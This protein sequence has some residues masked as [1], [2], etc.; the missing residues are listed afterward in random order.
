VAVYVWFG[1]PRW[2]DPAP[3]A[4]PSIAEEG[5]AVRVAVWL[6]VQ[7]VEAF[8]LRSG[9]IPGAQELGP[10]PPSVEYQRLDAQSY[11]LAGMGDRVG[12]TY[13]S[14]EPL[15]NLQDAVRQL[16]PGTIDP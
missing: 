12:V 3:P 8:R 10:L 2:L 15:E 4:L 7:Q 5:A 13:S 16:L 6:G 9:R 1:S 14:G 11:I